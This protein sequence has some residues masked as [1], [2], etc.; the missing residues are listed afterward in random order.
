M[1][2]AFLWREQAFATAATLPILKARD[3]R[4]FAL[5]Y[6]CVTGR[7]AV[8]R[9]FDFQHI[10]S[11]RKS[12]YRYILEFIRKSHLNCELYS[13]I[14]HTHACEHGIKLFPRKNTSEVYEP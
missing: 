3:G 1:A 13:A 5:L 12:T 8:S 2:R 11:S 14:R 10:V 6:K 4:Q 9:A 7:T